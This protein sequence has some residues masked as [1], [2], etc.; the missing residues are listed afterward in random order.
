MV[1]SHYKLNFDLGKKMKSI[2]TAKKDTFEISK[3][4]K[5]G[6]CNL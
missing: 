5:R 6:E 1:V 4:A 2:S 3:I